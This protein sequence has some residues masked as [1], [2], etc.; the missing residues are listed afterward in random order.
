MAGKVVVIHYWDTSCELCIEGFDELKR[1]RS[2]YK[3]E[4]VLV[5]ANLDRELSTAKSFL[6]KNKAVSWPQ[7]WAAGGGDASPLA[8][9]L[10]V[11]VMPTLI[12]IDQKGRLV[13]SNLP[14]SDLD[15][16]IQR[17]QKRN[18]KREK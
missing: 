8:L 12:L 10:G 2:K 1:L 11:S 17:L 6:A 3:N 5:G 16:E 9:Q 4:I 7:L 13:E 15:R 14:V 18:A